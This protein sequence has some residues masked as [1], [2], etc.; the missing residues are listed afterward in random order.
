MPSTPISKLANLGPKVSTRP[1]FWTDLARRAWGSSFSLPDP[2]V[3]EFSDGR[4]FDSTDQ[5]STGLYNGG[6]TGA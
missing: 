4:K 3:Y 6:A 5:G 2:G 1:L